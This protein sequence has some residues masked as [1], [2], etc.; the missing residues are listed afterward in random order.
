MMILCLP[1]TFLQK[2]Q[3][4]SSMIYMGKI[5]KSQFSKTVEDLC[6]IFGTLTLFNQENENISM[7]RSVDDL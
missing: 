2:G 7:S 1:L 3:F 5:L 6:I 4:D